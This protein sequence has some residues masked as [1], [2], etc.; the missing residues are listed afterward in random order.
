MS[1]YASRRSP[2]ER[3]NSAMAANARRLR[4]PAA[5]PPMTRNPA[6]TGGARLGYCSIAEFSLHG[7]DKRAK[8][9]LCFAEL[10]GRLGHDLGRLPR[11]ALC[12]AKNPSVH[13]CGRRTLE[14]EKRR[15]EAR[16]SLV[17][18]IDE[19]AFVEFL[20]NRCVHHVFEF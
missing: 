1:L 14:R 20:N 18:I 3:F 8:T 6:S 2:G 10:A 12:F 13:R 9:C 17:E 4:S 5:S 16:R 15:S 11:A 19:P 7:R